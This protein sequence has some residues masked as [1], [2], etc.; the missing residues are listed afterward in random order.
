MR[1]VST[2]YTNKSNDEIRKIAGRVVIDWDLSGTFI[3]ESSHQIVLEVERK[4]NE[5]L[6]GISV[7]LADIQLNNY[8]DRYTP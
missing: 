4:I 8:D 5:P 7:S 6:G 3:D 2:N 1:V